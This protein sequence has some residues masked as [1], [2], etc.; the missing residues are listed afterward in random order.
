MTE[1][2]GIIIIMYYCNNLI[3]RLYFQSLDFNNTLNEYNIII[4]TDNIVQIHEIHLI[5]LSLDNLNII[6]L[7]LI[8]YISLIVCKI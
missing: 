5:L 1:L 3:V 2:N 8:I 6:I 4:T 7:M